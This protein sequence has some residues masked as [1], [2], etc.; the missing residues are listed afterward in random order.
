MCFPDS[1]Y[2]Y[3]MGM[4]APAKTP[5]AIVERLRAETEKALKHPNVVEKFAAQGIEPML[6]TPV[7]FDA[8]IKKEIESNIAL[9]KAAG[10]KFN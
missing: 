5:T 6:L 10:L 9:V 2:V 8:L 4:L 1:D 7:Q 3:W